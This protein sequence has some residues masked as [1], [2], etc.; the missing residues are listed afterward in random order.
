M[1]LRRKL[2]SVVLALSLLLSMAGVASADLGQPAQAAAYA[3]M[4]ALNLVTGVKLN[5][6][7]V[8]PALDQE[9]TRAQMVTILVRAFGR[10]QDAQL[11]TGVTL[12]PDV[13]ASH[14]ASGYI[15][16]AQKL[17]EEKQIAIGRPGG[18][19]DPDAKVTIAEVLAFNMK[20]LGVQPDRSQSWPRDY[21]QGAVSAGLIPQADGDLLKLIGGNNATRGM[22]FALADGIF[23]NY[24]G[25]PGGK[26]VYTAYV[27]TQAPTITLTGD[28]PESTEDELVTIEG[29]VDADVVALYLEN[30][31]VN[32]S[33]SGTFS[34]D[35]EL[36]F[37]TN[38]LR[39]RAEDLAGNTASASVT[40]ER[41]APV[42]VPVGPFVREVTADKTTVAA[43]EKVQL[44]AIDENGEPI[45]EGV[46]WT[47]DNENAI[48]TGNGVFQSPVPG[49]YIV[50]ATVGP[51]SSFIPI[52]VYGTPAKLRIEAT[53]TVANGVSKKPVTVTAL[54][55][56]G[57]PVL[58]FGANEEKVTLTGPGITVYD[59]DGN[60]A[61]EVT[62]KNGA[63]TFL[64]TVPASLAGESFTLTATYGEGDDAITETAEFDALF[65]A[66]A[67]LKAEGPAFIAANT[68]TTTPEGA[69][70]VW[71]VDQDGAPVAD[72]YEVTA[73]ITGPATLV[74]ESDI[75]N[76]E[77][78]PAG[79]RISNFNHVGVQ[80]KI[81]LL[82]TVDGVGSTSLTIN[83]LI[84]GSPS[85]LE[86]KPEK[87]TVKATDP[88]VFTVTV[89]DS[90]G[91]PVTLNS[92][93]EL[94]ITLPDSVADKFEL[95]DGLPVISAGEGSTTFEIKA[96]KAFLGDLDV[97]VQNTGGN[98]VGRT[99]VTV[100]PGS[101]ETVAFDREQA[102]VPLIAPTATFYGFLADELGNPV[103]VQ[104][105]TLEVYVQEVSST[106]ATTGN[107][108]TRVTING[109][110]T[111]DTKPLVVKTNADGKVELKVVATPQSNKVYML[112]LTDE[113]NNESA[114]TYL[115][116]VN[117]VPGEL[118]VSTYKYVTA[119][120]TYRE[121]TSLNAG[122]KFWVKVTVTDNYGG[123]VNGIAD[124]LKLISDDVFSANGVTLTD[125]STFTFEDNT[126]WEIQYP[127][128]AEAMDLADGDYVLELYA[129]KSGQQ[130]VK[131]AYDLTLD[132]VTGSKTVT[133]RAT[134]VAGVKA[135]GGKEVKVK[136]NS[137]T[138]PYTLELVD[139]FGNP[140]TSTLTQEI[141]WEVEDEDGNPA[142]DKVG[143]RLSQSGG[144]VSKVTTK[145]KTNV[146][147]DV[148][149]E[150]TYTVT[151]STGEF[152]GTWTVIVEK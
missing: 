139:H 110:T 22:A 65:P 86:V 102:I 39:L 25:L 21:I 9:L 93:T 55:S 148:N 108:T 135:N 145:S 103:V 34:V 57:T 33:A 147:L 27:D 143:F 48:V 24:K 107:N 100:V 56:N 64:I 45:T 69:I 3:R 41:K 37:G 29:T 79:F 133:V 98:L 36:D 78:S 47:V 32:L 95:P 42:P 58:N 126:W 31:K 87:S 20:F 46:T 129:G 130:A 12:Y 35:A 67:G 152:T 38:V 81:V 122:E 16:V 18:L 5:D 124:D 120:D 117:T 118:K 113:E 72:S 53:D 131:V 11:L 30:Q 73:Q 151:F 77:D 114:Y 62:A 4:S 28:L 52:N 26:S 70:R 44:T 149:T 88:I 96:T 90:N 115:L 116:L 49:R 141:T 97:K 40:I 71:V 63:A 144:N 138:G 112:K 14:W 101:I 54:D 105:H 150:G 82:F 125:S 59:E 15:T 50:T 99:T 1:A 104:N 8:V 121:T 146:Y 132:A 140:A 7:S 66:P 84:A 80:G 10:E 142:N 91:V 76:G 92:E 43:F 60:E 23:Y 85:K 89:Q 136:V 94:E 51:S 111:S 83:Q 123:P 13:P 109:K 106:D 134:T 128:L 119:T 2:L 127:E 17:A 75:Y 61:T 74:N 68:G 19:F 6:G 137:V